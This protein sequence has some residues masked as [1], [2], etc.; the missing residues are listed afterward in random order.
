MFQTVQFVQGI[1]VERYD[2][3]IEDSYRKVSPIVD[4]KNAFCA[5]VQNVLLSSVCLMCRQ[6][7][8]VTEF[9][10]SNY[11]EVNSQCIA[12][13]QLFLLF[14]FIEVF[15]GCNSLRFLV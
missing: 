13:C 5:H 11:S 2:P 15:P 8:F 7:V 10:L 1:F 6:N 12:S 3:T 9:K 4:P 14:R